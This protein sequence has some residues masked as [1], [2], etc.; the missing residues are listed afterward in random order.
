MTKSIQD[1]FVKMPPHDHES[2]VCL[3]G[4]IMLDN[5]IFHELDSMIQ[6]GD[7]YFRGHQTIYETIHSMLSNDETVDIVTLCEKLKSTDSL[8]KAGGIPVIA[9]LVDNVPTTAHFLNYAGIIKRKAQYRKIIK[10]SMIAHTKAFSEEMPVNDLVS[11]IE[12]NAIKII[13]N[14]GPQKDI[15]IK[16]LLTE[17]IQEVSQIQESGTLGIPTGFVDL[18]KLT[19]GLVPKDLIVLAARPGMGK[20]AL[21]INVMKNVARNGHSSLMFSLE[22]G[23]GQVVQRILSNESDIHL[24]KIRGGYLSKENWDQIL[25]A[26]NDLGNDSIFIDDSPSLKLGELRIR[27]KKYLTKFDLKFIIVDYLQLVQV[28]KQGRSRENEVAEISRG[29]KAISKDFNI[30]VLAISQLSRAVE[31]REDKTPRLADLRESGAIEQDADIVIF[32][33][34]NKDIDPIKTLL[35]VAKHRNGRTGTIHLNFYEDIQKFRNR[36]ED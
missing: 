30:P 16:S 19:G 27:T 24:H 13:Q 17:T 33:Y 20:S 12:H 8:E 1:A 22:M 32:I 18:D 11:L 26:S 6:A 3:L 29:L 15:H 9:G 5:S 35:R 23:T 10:L 28:D 21:A 2:E 7:F 36:L 31:Q 14:G 4:S 25:S 34:R